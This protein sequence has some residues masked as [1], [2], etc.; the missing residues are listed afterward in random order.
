MR[1]LEVVVVG[2]GI[3][4]LQT[5][6]ALASDGHTVTILESAKSFEEVGAGIRVPPNSSRFGN[7]WGVDY[8]K[9]KK[10]VS[11]GNRFVDWQGRTL[12]DCDFGDVESRDGAPYYFIHRADLVKLLV[13]TVQEN[14]R[15][16]IRTGCRVVSYDYDVPSVTLSTGEVLKAD[17]V[18]CAD[19]IKSAVRDTINGRHVA[20]QDTGDVAYRI[21]VPAKLLLEDSTMAHLVQN[22]WAVHW[23]GPEG[24]A[25]GYP[26]REGELYNIIIDVTHSSDLGEPL[27]DEG[28]VWKSARSNV[29]LVERFKDWCPEVKRLCAMTGDY[30]K[31]KLADFDQ[32]DRWVHPSGKVCLL[33]DACH[34]MMPYMAQGAAQATEDAATLAAALTAHEGMSEALHAYERQRKPRTTYV[35]RNTRV[36]QEHLHLYDG[37]AKEE[38]D[39]MMQL[40][41]P[42]NPMFWG[43]SERKDWLFGHDAS[44][45]RADGNIPALPPMPPDEARVYKEKEGTRSKL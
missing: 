45:L 18:V 2:A 1:N 19:G 42:S 16:S 36:L 28:Q 25:V 8:S 44:E 38:R 5:A 21:L 33:G 32:L 41:N 9:V 27:P 17:L 34:P 39:R 7:R 10:E 29:E 3:G 30:L 23:M 12:L 11:L 43:C 37:P 26:L 4:G 15:T 40:D 31:W 20:P 24:H 22:P 14:E 35:A 13:G 6:L